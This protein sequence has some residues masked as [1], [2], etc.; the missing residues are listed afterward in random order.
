VELLEIREP[1]KKKLFEREKTLTLES[2][3]EKRF[4]KPGEITFELPNIKPDC[5]SI[6]LYYEGNIKNM[7]F[8][9]SEGVIKENVVNGEVLW[10]CSEE[11]NRSF[12]GFLKV[13]HGIGGIKIN[14]VRND[15]VFESKWEYSLRVFRTFGLSN[16][17]DLYLNDKINWFLLNLEEARHISLNSKREMIGVLLKDGKIAHYFSDFEGF[18]W[19]IALDPGEYKLGL[20]LMDYEFPGN[21][22]LVYSMKAVRVLEE[23]VRST[24]YLTPGESSIFSFAIPT[25][26]KIGL[27]IKTTREVVK[28]RLYDVEW[29]LIGEG[30]QQ[31][32]NL[33]KGLYYFVLHVPVSEEA[34]SCTPILVGQKAP[35]DLPPEEVINRIIGK[36]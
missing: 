14:L 13:A 28:A 21:I 16:P 15:K 24:V 7:T 29:N 18:D 20:R 27:G 1:L 31:Y 10:S 36:R 5:D 34:V 11:T 30:E 4:S 8:F 3:I 12:G 25:K 17:S 9:S 35:P 22:N 19:Q 6:S 2:G 33:D 23:D 32:L 26:R